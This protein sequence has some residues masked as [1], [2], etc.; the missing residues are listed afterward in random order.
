VDPLHR[1]KLSHRRVDPGDDPNFPAA[2]TDLQEQFACGA[3][4]CRERALHAH[5]YGL[6]QQHPIQLHFPCLAGN[7][8][9]EKVRQLHGDGVVEQPIDPDFRPV[10]LAARGRPLL[11]P[12]PPGVIEVRQHD[13]PALNGQ[14]HQPTG[15]R[16]VHQLWHRVPGKGPVDDVFARCKM[17]HRQFTP[18]NDGHSLP[19]HLDVLRPQTGVAGQGDPVPDEDPPFLDKPPP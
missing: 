15:R 7:V 12:E 3:E 16:Y 4:P 13:P 17:H 14:S 18:P 11:Q 8:D 2:G 1:A 6:V 19:V 10:F 5:G 9:L